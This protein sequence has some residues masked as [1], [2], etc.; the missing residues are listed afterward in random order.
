MESVLK[1]RKSEDISAKEV[2]RYLTVASDV[3][4]ILEEE[5]TEGDSLEFVKR[6]LDEIR[7]IVQRISHIPEMD[8]VKPKGTKLPNDTQHNRFLDVYSNCKNFEVI[9]TSDGG[10][11]SGV[12][13]PDE[14]MIHFEPGWG[15]FGYYVIKRI[16]DGLLVD[17]WSAEYH[18]IILTY[19]AGKRQA[20]FAD[21]FIDC[22]PSIGCDTFTLV[23]STG[24]KSETI[25]A[26][27]YRRLRYDEN[28]FY[29]YQTIGKKVIRYCMYVRSEFTV[30][31]C[32]NG[33]NFTFE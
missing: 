29:D 13:K 19:E 30:E 15:S 5:S 16:K 33:V 21:S 27:E 24:V 26:G 6:R 8:S 22:I 28:N 18:H 14:Y 2:C 9:Q 1:K 7:T 17:A 4:N 23:E 25:Q 32:I 10:F 31:A 12:L 20:V 11:C 3:C